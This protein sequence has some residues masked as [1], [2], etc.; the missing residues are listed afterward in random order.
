MDRNR[1]MLDYGFSDT[2]YEELLE[3]INTTSATEIRDLCATYF[4]PQ[5]LVEIVCGG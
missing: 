1:I 2:Y 3:I 5:N 4:E